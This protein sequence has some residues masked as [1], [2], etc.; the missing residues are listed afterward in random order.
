MLDKSKNY[1]IDVTELTKKEK[2]RLQEE[3]FK[4]GYSWR[5]NTQEV[6]DFNFDF[7][8]L[9]NLGI[10]YCND[11]I[12]F[13]RHKSILIQI[14]DIMLE[15]E[16]EPIITPQGITLRDYFA[17]LALN[18]LITKNEWSFEDFAQEAYKHA[19]AMLEERNK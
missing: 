11:K 9:D 10:S 3:L 18:S 5:S 19:D 1:K 12:Y 13:I 4:Q 2:K 7:L 6:A 8:F 15:Q 14:S 17:G 16:S